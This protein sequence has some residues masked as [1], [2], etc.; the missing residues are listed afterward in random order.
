MRSSWSQLRH[1][2]QDF[3][4]TRVFHLRFATN[5]GW[6]LVLYHVMTTDFAGTENPMKDEH[7]KVGSLNLLIS[8]G[9]AK[10][11]IL[12]VLVSGLQEKDETKPMISKQI[13]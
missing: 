6:R 9:R 11:S 1:R 4:L 3:P 2:G 12:P 7:L 5:L 8:S 10:H 13:A